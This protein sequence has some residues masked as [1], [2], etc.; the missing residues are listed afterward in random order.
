MRTLAV[1]ALLLLLLPAPPAVSEPE[2][3]PAAPAVP[4]APILYELRDLK[5]A[6][7]TQ[8][9]AG[10]ETILR[11]YFEFK[12]EQG[13]HNIVYEEATGAPPL[14]AVTSLREISRAWDSSCAIDIECSAKAFCTGDCR[15]MYY[16]VANTPGDTLAPD[17]NKCRIQYFS[18]EKGAGSAGHAAAPPAAGAP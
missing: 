6:G 15:M 5:P 13:S 1:F 10:G 9:S 14:R 7:I 16:E 2:S 3:K 4:S 18:C 8:F 11:Q 17:R 12:N